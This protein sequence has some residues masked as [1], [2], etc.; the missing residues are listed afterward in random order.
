MAVLLSSL[1]WW[2][3]LLL[4]GIAIPIYV[5]VLCIYRLTLHPLA[6]YPGPLIA[7][8]TEWSIVYQTA[9]GDRH[10]DL[11]KGHEKYVQEGPIV[12]VGPNTLSFNTVS[13]VK[14][15][16]FN[17]K[18]NVQKSKWYSI[19]EASAGDEDSIHA[20]IDRNVHASRRRVIEHAFTEKGLRSAERYLVLNVQTFREIIQESIKDEKWSSPFNMSQWAT[21]LNYDIMGDL[22][23]GRRFNCMTSEE[24]RFVPG[25]LMNGT[26]FIYTFASLPFGSILR[27]ILGSGILAKPWIGG[28]MARDEMRFYQYSDEVLADRVAQEEKAG[29]DD[30]SSARKDMMHYILNAKDPQTGEGFSR[31][32][33]TAES[34]LLI[35]AGADTT[36]T[37]LA[38]AFFYLL[39]NP[40]VMELLVK[41]IMSFASSRGDGEITP[42][43][44]IRL[45][46]LR[47]V[48]DETLRLSPPVPSLLPREVLKGGIRIG[49]ELIPEGSVVGVPTYAIHHNPEYYPEPDMFYPERWLVASEDEA[50]SSAIPRSSEAVSV[51]R[52]AFSPFSQGA[53]GCI[54]RQLAY[55]ELHAALFM[56]LHRFD[57]RLAKDAATGK[58]M[59]NSKAWR[60]GSVPVM[61]PEDQKDDWR[62][63][64]KRRQEFQLFDRFL[65]DRSGPMVEFKERLV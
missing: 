53:R 9:T 14:E 59:K 39:H 28:S 16:Y 60:E 18:G 64:R 38:A 43:E 21:Y 52:E 25:V 49:E 61:D 17:R 57:V 31:Q 33:L 51:A 56:L 65:S 46:Y 37:T 62:E 40:R 5:F 47:A 45:P 2:Q 4:L 12:R 54:G 13:A 30:D 11:L 3:S 29:R 44:T 58:V 35:A 55:L 22:V 41:E 1:S 26:A 32:H 42:F 23:F 63:E 24:H 6:Q 8:L 15:V 19:I 27:K 20:E 10:L 7:K 36:S 48:I 50:A 34:G